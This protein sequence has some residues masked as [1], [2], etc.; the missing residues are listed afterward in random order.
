MR[1]T[2]RGLGVD[3]STLKPAADAMT[4]T[5]VTMTVIDDCGHFSAY[6]HPDQ[7]AAALLELVKRVG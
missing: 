6:E 7:V 3:I 1:S 5:D 2:A 4:K